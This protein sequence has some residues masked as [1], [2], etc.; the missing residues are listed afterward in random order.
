MKYYK[1]KNGN[2]SFEYDVSDKLSEIEK[3]LEIY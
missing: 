1:F 2:G 3:L